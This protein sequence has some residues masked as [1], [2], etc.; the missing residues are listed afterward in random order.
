M[1]GKN[2]FVMISFF[3]ILTKAYHISYECF[4]MWIQLF[5][6]YLTFSFDVLPLQKKH[7]WIFYITE[8]FYWLQTSMRENKGQTHCL[9]SGLYLWKGPWHYLK[10][11]LIVENVIIFNP[12]CITKGGNLH[13]IYKR[14]LNMYNTMILILFHIYIVKYNI[15]VNY[16][17]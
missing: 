10:E 17:F 15:I 8:A 6:I 1:G 2:L 9:E 7:L 5:F 13:M 16:E 3:S 12:Q 4:D 11:L 14:Q